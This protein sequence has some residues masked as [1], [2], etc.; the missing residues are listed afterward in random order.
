[1]PLIIRAQILASGAGKLVSNA[2][3]SSTLPARPAQLSLTNNLR[4]PWPVFM[5]NWELRD[6]DEG[7]G[8]HAMAIP[9]G[10]DRVPDCS[11][12]PLCHSAKGLLIHRL[13]QVGQ[14]RREGYWGFETG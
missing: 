8:A 12:P 4:L 9:Y 1:M 13:D 14:V 3:K 7:V 5:V 6:L 11:T 10:I 2:L